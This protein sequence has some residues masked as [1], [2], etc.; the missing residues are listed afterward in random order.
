VGERGRRPGPGDDERTQRRA[1]GSE[2]AEHLGGLV[3][4]RPGRGHPV[5]EGGPARPERAGPA[6]DD[7]R[8][9]APRPG[10][11]RVEQL[12]ELDRCHRV[13]RGEARTIR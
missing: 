4:R 3:E 11:E 5:R 1:V 13:G 7:A 2:R 9:P 8:E 6:V 12:V 10:V